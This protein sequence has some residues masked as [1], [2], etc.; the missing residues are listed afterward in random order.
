M[1]KLELY[2]ALERAEGRI[3]S[4][5][6]QVSSSESLTLSCIMPAEKYA[7]LPVYPSSRLHCAKGELCIQILLSAIEFL[8]SRTVTLAPWSRRH[9]DL[10]K[11]QEWFN[12]HVIFFLY[13]TSG[14]PVLLLFAFCLSASSFCRLF[15]DYSEIPKQVPFPPNLQG[16]A[17]KAPPFSQMC[18]DGMN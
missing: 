11:A 1:E 9:A 10:N 16:L 17:K 12:I 8:G 14:F 6:K 4:L 18:R 5:E 2:Q 15:V 7:S 13:F 3:M